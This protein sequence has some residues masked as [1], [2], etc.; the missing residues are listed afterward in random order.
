IMDLPRF[1]GHAKGAIMRQVRPVAKRR[2]PDSSV[3][4]SRR[5]QFDGAARGK[6]LKQADV[7]AGNGPPDALTTAEKAELTQLRR[8]VERGKLYAMKQRGYV[9]GSRHV[10]SAAGLAERL[11]R[12]PPLPQVRE[13]ARQRSALP[14]D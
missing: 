1:G 5:R 13:R 3:Q 12:M 4:N 14:G 7:D 10:S 9:F 6:W 2:S 8:E 11:L